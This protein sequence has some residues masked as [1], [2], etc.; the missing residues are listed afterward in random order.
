[1]INEFEEEYENEE[2]NQRGFGEIHVVISTVDQFIDGTL[3]LPENVRFRNSSPDN[4]LFYFLN[5]GFQF[6]TLK[7]CEI[8]D[9]KNLAFRPDISPVLHIRVAAIV[10]IQIVNYE[11]DEEYKI[12][13]YN[14]RIG[15]EVEDETEVLF[16]CIEIDKSRSV[17]KTKR[18]SKKKT[19]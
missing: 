12:K 5:G 9:R 1:M 10:T 13:Q 3:V 15:G 17:S 7:N 19:D 18:K 14:A 6:I 8:K 16:N 4:M 11:S 2:E